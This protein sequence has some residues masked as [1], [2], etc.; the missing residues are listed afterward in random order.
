MVISGTM[1][2]LF[3][4]RG[5]LDLAFQ[6]ATTNDLSTKKALKYVLSDLAAKLSSD[7]LVFGVG[8]GAAY[9]WPNSGASTVQAALTDQSPCRDVLPFTQPDQEEESKQKASR[10][11]DK[12]SQDQQ[13]HIVNID[14]MLAMSTSRPAVAPVIE[15]ESGGHHYVTMTLPIDVVAF[16]APEEPWGRARILLV[17]AIHRQ[18]TDLESCIWKY[19]KGSSIIVPEPLH[20]MLPGEKGLQTVAYPS[21]IPDSELG[22]YREELH[23]RFQLPRDRPYFRRSNAYH[24]PD[25]PPGDGYIRNPHAHLNPLG[26]ECGT[27]CTVQGTYSYH[28]YMQ[29]RVDDSGWGCA[30]R[31]LQTVCSWFRHQGYTDR[32]IP[33]HR[34]IQQA[35][36]DAGDKPAVFV[37][38][39]QWIGSIEVQLVLDQWLGVTSKILFVSRG[40]EL[41]AKGRDLAHHFQSQGSPVMIGGGVLAHT[42]LGVAWNE[43]TGQ[44]RF[45]V[46]DPHYPG[47]EDLSAVVEKGWCG[48]KGPE[49]WNQDAYYNLCLPQR[50]EVI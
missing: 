49:F 29:D 5:G 32:P 27:V 37:G 38:S 20:F 50:P 10:K 30:Y 23:D 43:T 22:A 9:F 25:E 6:L 35:L 24:F 4:I 47:A 42:I 48:W 7:A 12:K 3:R 14:L 41:A 17:G 2:L 33:S 11:K 18:L 46:L 45:L 31:S 26:P 15:R 8:R 21:G 44:I 34:E 40:S 19:M 13:Q 36:V 39:R 28:H 16:V 1:D